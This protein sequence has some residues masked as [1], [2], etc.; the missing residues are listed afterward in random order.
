MREAQMHFEELVKEKK[1]EK[2][3]KC[4]SKNYLKNIS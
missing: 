1:D 3:I 2:M 4:E